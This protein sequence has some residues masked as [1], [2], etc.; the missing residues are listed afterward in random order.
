MTLDWIYRTEW[1]EGVKILI[2]DAT[3]LLA[4]RHLQFGGQLRNAQRG[5]EGIFPSNMFNTQ[6]GSF[7]CPTLLRC[8]GVLL[9]CTAKE[10]GLL[11]CTEAL[12]TVLPLPLWWPT[13]EIGPA[14][15]PKILLTVLFN[16]LLQ[17]K[18]WEGQNPYLGRTIR[19]TTEGIEI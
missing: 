10:S 8:S 13:T 9:C 14:V 19:W 5:G 11:R 12:L 1:G 15:Q 18:G 4:V 17:D 7:P 2:S 6:R 3:L 16:I